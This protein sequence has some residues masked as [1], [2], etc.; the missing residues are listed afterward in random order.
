MASAAS[1]LAER[2][3]NSLADASNEVRH[4][5]LRTPRRKFVLA[6]AAV[7]VA[8][9][10]AWPLTARFSI[11]TIRSWCRLKFRSRDYPKPGME[12]QSRSSVIFTMTT[13]ARGAAGQGN[14][15]GEPFRIY[16]DGR[17]CAV[18]LFKGTGQSG[19]SAKP[20]RR[21]RPEHPFDGVL[22]EAFR[23]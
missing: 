5:R 4:L 17:F 19:L 23:Q 11:R 21:E 9:A 12:L 8:G 14:S 3:I 22:V 20:G 10:L 2:P 18:P 1:I 6:S 7:G 15:C 16:S 13:A